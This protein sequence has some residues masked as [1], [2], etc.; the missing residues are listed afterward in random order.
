MIGTNNFLVDQT[1]DEI[2]GEIITLQQ[3][4]L[5][6]NTKINILFISLF[7]IFADK[8]RAISKSVNAALKGHFGYYFVNISGKFINHCTV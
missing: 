5:K 4:V 3:Q 1:L 8:Y 7:P 6:I 2:I